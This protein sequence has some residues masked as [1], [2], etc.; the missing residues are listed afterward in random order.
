MS[1]TKDFFISMG[2]SLPHVDG[3]YVIVQNKEFENATP[4]LVNN[5]RIGDIR[6]KW[7]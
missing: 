4:V 7:S 1:K 3:E 5:S 6:I 2:Y